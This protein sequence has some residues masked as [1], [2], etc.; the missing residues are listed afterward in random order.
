MR[1]Q[2]LGGALPK[3]IRGRE[4]TRT[5]VQNSDPERMPAP[6]NVP[7][8]PLYPQAPCS[9]GAWAWW[10]CWG[11]QLDCKTTT[12]WKPLLMA[13]ARFDLS[14]FGFALCIVHIYLNVSSFQRGQ[15]FSC[16]LLP[17]GPPVLWGQDSGQITSIFP[18]APG[19]APICVVWV[20]EYLGDWK[21]EKNN[22]SIG[23]RVGTWQLAAS[24]H[25]RG[26]TGWRLRAGVTGTW[27]LSVCHSLAVWPQA[28]SFL[29]LCLRLPVCKWGQCEPLTLLRCC[30]N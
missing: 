21:D 10:A 22:N 12:S 14:W 7:H 28:I 25:A 18:T 4:G 6:A 23:G 5:P 3:K 19:S 17:I 13:P 26:E 30:H 11:F 1:K 20:N 15:T 16:L 9:Q 8:Y 29:F 24:G 2:R 27:V